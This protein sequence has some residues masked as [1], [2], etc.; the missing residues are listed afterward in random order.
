MLEPIWQWK[1]PNRRDNLK[2]IN[3]KINIYIF[4]EAQQ[5]SRIFFTRSNLQST[6]SEQDLSL[7]LWY[8]VKFNGMIILEQENGVNDSFTKLKQNTMNE[9]KTR[10]KE[11]NG[12]K[13]KKDY[14]VADS[15]LLHCLVIFDFIDRLFEEH[16]FPFIRRTKTNARARSDR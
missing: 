13:N 12:A 9:T 8:H 16:N 1:R 10:N 14:M 2:S 6:E 3:S 11:R 7:R 4:F 15:G 5:S